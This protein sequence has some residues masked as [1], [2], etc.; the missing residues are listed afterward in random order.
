MALQED[1]RKITLRLGI[2]Q[3]VIVVIFSILAVAFWVLQVVQQIKQ[4]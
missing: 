4:S 3:G 1:R 2:L